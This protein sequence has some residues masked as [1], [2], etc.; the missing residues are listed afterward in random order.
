MVISFVTACGSN[1][2]V[3]NNKQKEA[4][5]ID[6]TAGPPTY[7]YKTK[8]DYSNLVPVNLSDDKSTIISFPHPKDI[9][10]NGE[11]AI[12]VELT[13]GYLLDNRGISENVA[14][15]NITYADYSKLKNTPS[16]DSLY[17]L[18][19]EKEPLVELYFCGNR[20]QYKDEVKQLNK[21]ITDGNLKRCKK[22][23]GK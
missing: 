9:Y 21:L 13:D 4:M 11:L 15:L 3:D 23:V 6:F 17:S 10:Y 14:F 22:I 7:I 1:K 19:I 8:A 5:E 12:P 18:I 20:H 16:V 2:K